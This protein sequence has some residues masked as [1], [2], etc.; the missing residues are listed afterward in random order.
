MMIFSIDGR[1]GQ[2]RTHNISEHSCSNQGRVS[3]KGQMFSAPMNWNDTLEQLRHMEASESLVTL[4]VQGA[5][6]AA[7]VR[8][9]ISAGLVDLNR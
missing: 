9:T 2:R 1:V 4:P 6:L 8:I 3:F 5:V 7:R